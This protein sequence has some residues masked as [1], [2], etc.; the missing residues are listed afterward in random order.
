MARLIKMADQYDPKRERF[1]TGCAQISAQAH[2]GAGERNGS[3]RE[4][5]LVLAELIYDQET[6]SLATWICPHLSVASKLMALAARAG[7]RIK[8][9]QEVTEMYLGEREKRMGTGRTC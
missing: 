8:P 5:V 3:I 7:I 6:R 1:Q 2:R 4:Q 9:V